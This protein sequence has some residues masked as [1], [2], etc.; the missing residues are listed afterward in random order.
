MHHTGCILRVVYFGGL[1]ADMQNM[2]APC[3]SSDLVF[4]QL[5]GQNHEFQFNSLNSGHKLTSTLVGSA[6]QICK[7]VAVLFFCC[8]FSLISCAWTTNARKND[9]SFLF[10]FCVI[11][12]WGRFMWFF[13]GSP[14]AFT[15]VAAIHPGSTKNMTSNKHWYTDRRGQSH[16]GGMVRKR[17]RMNV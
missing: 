15:E 8:F 7:G 5:K 10:T 9:L 4:T 1:I 14:L 17:V 13:F 16:T 11:F 6:L 2:L 12:G 3:P